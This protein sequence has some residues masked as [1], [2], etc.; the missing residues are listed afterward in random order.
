M[1]TTITLHTFIPVLPEILVAVM[2]M[3]IMLADLFLSHKYKNI[4]Y[5]LSQLTLV[6]V[7]IIGWIYFNKENA[8]AFGYQFYIDNLTILLKGFIYLITFLIFVY[9]RTYL[10]ENKIPKGEY[11]VLTLLSM[12]GAMVLV[13]AGSLVTIYIGL[14]LLSLPLYALIAMRR[15]YYPGSEAAIKYFILGAVM[16]ALLLYGM[17]F[18]YGITGHL[19][20]VGIAQYFSS[21]TSDYRMIALFSMVFFIVVSAFKLGAAPFHQWVPDVY[22]GS[23]NMTTAYLATVPKIAAYGMLVTLL[24][25]ALVAFSVQWSEVLM[26]LAIISIFIGNIVALVQ[27]NLK[28]MFAYSTISHV[29]FIFLGLSMLDSIGYAAAMYYVLVY[30]IMS[31]GGFGIIM[32]LSQKGKEFQEIKDLSG[33]NKR[34]AWLAFMML[35]L[36]F[37]MAGVPPF[38]GFTSKLLVLNSLMQQGHYLLTVYVLLMSVIGS[39]YYLRVIKVMYF[40]KCDDDTPIIVSKDGMAAITI[41]CLLVLLFG[42]FP[43]YLTALINIIF[44]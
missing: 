44:K 40:D 3:V 37:S 36:M 14:E 39:F 33:L 28:R 26:V 29:G 18:I 24:T 38:A 43:L 20:I 32:L 23:P 19:D 1:S 5:I 9:S 25:K 17:S 8:Y 15:D 22:V 35:I 42:V 27:S 41:N 31:V 6:V 30:V 11:Y 10:E 4:T 13:S 7:G 16:S 34:N 12:L 21:S 2:A